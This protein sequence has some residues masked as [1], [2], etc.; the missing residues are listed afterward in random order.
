MGKVRT[1][2]RAAAHGDPQQLLLPP[3]Q[4]ATRATSTRCLAGHGL[5]P[6]HY[7]GFLWRGLAAGKRALFYYNHALSALYDPNDAYVSNVLGW[8]HQ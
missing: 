2:R 4:R 8:H 7:G 5:L 6:V 1:E 3:S